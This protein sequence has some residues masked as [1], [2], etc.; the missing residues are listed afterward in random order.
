MATDFDPAAWDGAKAEVQL[1]TDPRPT[2]EVNELADKRVKA[3]GRLV[4][5]PPPENEDVAQEDPEPT[6]FEPRVLAE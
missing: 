6:L 3:T 1:G 2:T 5:S 4:L